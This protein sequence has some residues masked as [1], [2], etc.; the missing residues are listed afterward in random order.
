MTTLPNTNKALLVIDAQNVILKD[1]Y[2]RD[3]KLAKLAQAVEKARANRTPVL[4]IQHSD[5]EIIEGSQDWEIVDELS[6]EQNEP[7]IGKHFRS[8]FVETDLH[9]RL[10]AIGVGHIIVGGAESNNCVRHTIHS[11][12]DLG[13]DVTLLQDA[14]TAI[15]FEW[16][17]FVVDAARVIDEQNIN[18]MNYQ[19][20]GRRAQ[21]L[22]VAEADF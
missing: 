15:S 4:W 14:H 21:A 8:S 9:V 2:Q 13:Y 20:P 6:P 19:L 3:E 22:T 18:F 1:C 12:L 17:G 16:G 7:V 10:Q 5:Q 11:A